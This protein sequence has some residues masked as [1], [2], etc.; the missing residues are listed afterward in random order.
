MSD[1]QKQQKQQKQQIPTAA[2][3][4]TH[5]QLKLEDAVQNFIEAWCYECGILDMLQGKDIGEINTVCPT[6]TLDTCPVYKR[7]KL[8]QSVTQAVGPASADAPA[9]GQELNQELNQ[10]LSQEK[11][12]PFIWRRKPTQ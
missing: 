9:K 10:E 8:L 11:E 4:L 7:I 3:I 1:N 5:T 6:S 2:R 12:E